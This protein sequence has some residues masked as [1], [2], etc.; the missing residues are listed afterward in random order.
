[1]LLICFSLG[2]KKECLL[3]GAEESHSTPRL[4]QDVVNKPDD[5]PSF[6]AGCVHRVGPDLLEK[7]LPKRHEF[8]IFFQ[9]APHQ[10]TLYRGYLDV[11][12]IL[13]AE[14]SL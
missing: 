6:L 13:H 10:E 9:L 1:M 12:T 7:Q 14:D 2:L 8:A 3:G 5:C 4:R 11:S